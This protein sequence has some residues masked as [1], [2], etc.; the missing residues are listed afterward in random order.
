VFLDGKS[1][2]DDIARSCMGKSVIPMI[3]Y[4]EIGSFCLPILKLADSKTGT[5]SLMSNQEKS[6]D[7]RWSKPWSKA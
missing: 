5:S 1:A 7:L 4:I 6:S 3:R 2:S